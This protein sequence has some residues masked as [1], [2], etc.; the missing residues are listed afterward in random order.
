MT[1]AAIL[2]DFGGVLADAP[3]RAD[4]PELVLRL[5]NLTDGVLTPG[6]I[7]RS[8]I[9]GAARYARWRD[10]DEPDELPHLDVWERFVIADWPRP[11]QARVRANVTRLSYDWARRDDWT[12]R[13]GIAEFLTA[14]A[15]RN[16]P[17]AV[18][19][20]TLCGAAHRDYLAKAGVGQL[21]AAQIY[22][23]EA[24]VR[25][26]NPQMIWNATDTLGI[27]PADCW[28]V[29]DSRQRDITC[30]RRAD[31]GTAIL[32]PSGR[33]DT[34]DNHPEPD[35]VVPDGHGLLAL[36]HNL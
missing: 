29:G 19:S 20:N 11:A 25:K 3:F 23:D 15:A 16:I 34:P 28:F 35:H 24:G 14:A 1:P 33:A 27:P 31:I 22:S 26:P 9:D 12:L 4:P 10:E 7:Q 2:L 8:L 18:V 5:Y 36:L 21:F 32:M 13:P 6:R 17:L 30:A